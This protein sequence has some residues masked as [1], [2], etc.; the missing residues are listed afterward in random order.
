MRPLY[1]FLITVL[2]APLASAQGWSPWATD[3]VFQGIEVRHR[4][5]GYN[6]FAGRYLWDVQLRNRY[7]RSVDLAWAA[8]PQRLH[9]TQAQ[10]DQA[11]SVAAGEAVQAHHTAPVDCSSRLQVRVRD[12]K[13][14]GEGPS[15]ATAGPPPPPP[16]PARMGGIGGTWRSR[17]PEPFQKTLSVHVV[18]DT[19]QG[20]WSSPGFSFQVI[21]PLPK[22]VHGSVSV[23]A[24]GGPR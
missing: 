10:L 1:L 19:I 2:W 22:N 18:G 7:Q 14:A 8:E 3:E 11:F 24:G 12:V 13:P 20:A 16:P 6:E 15:V 5:T 21:T 23:D 9:G 4:C 17:D